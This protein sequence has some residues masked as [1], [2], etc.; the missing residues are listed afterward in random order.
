MSRKKVMIV[1]DDEDLHL[2]YSLYLQGQDF[3]VV[4]AFNGEQGLELVEKENPDLI[5]LD[6]I[7]PVMDGE[8]F[9]VTLRTERNRLDVPVII[10]SVNDR[11]PQRMYDLG[12]IFTTLKKPFTIE[13]LLSH[14]H[15]A[16]KSGS[17]PE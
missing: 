15:A 17:S 1:E 16:L 11:I 3:D 4:Q 8:T 14:I 12:N 6:M 10:A 7:M 13:T 5:I 9:F 2:L